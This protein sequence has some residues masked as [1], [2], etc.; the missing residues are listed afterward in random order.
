M[1]QKVL[2]LFPNLT[3]AQA[4]ELESLIECFLSDGVISEKEKLYLS[5]KSAALGIGAESLLKCVETELS[6]RLRE[7]E[8]KSSQESELDELIEIF[9]E[10]GVITDAERAILLDKAKALHLDE[11]QFREKISS[12]EA[13]R[14]VKQDS[15]QETEHHVTVQPRVE[16][17]EPSK[18]VANTGSNYSKQKRK[19][20]KV[21]LLTIL[22]PC[23]VIA[24]CAA[25]LLFLLS[26]RS[27][28]PQ[29]LDKYAESHPSL[30]FQSA[31]LRKYLVY[32]TPDGTNEHLF[33]QE[34]FQVKASG[35]Y[36]F[37]LTKLK[38]DE[39]HSSDK[40]GR[41]VL[42]YRSDTYFPLSIDV[43][44]RQEDILQ[45]EQI[46][47]Q[48]ITAEEAA[49]IAKSLAAITAVAGGALGSSIG[50]KIGRAIGPEETLIG[51]LAGGAV[52]AVAT[53]AITYV[54]SKN[55]F[56]GLKL[57]KTIGAEK[58]ESFL[59]AAKQIMQGELLTLN[60]QSKDDLE[61]LR[62]KYEEKIQLQ[63]QDIAYTL[64]WNS[65]VVNFIYE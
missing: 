57:A 29:P 6:E 14:S 31:E 19:G 28:A 45:I 3:V 64:G 50:V 55:F 8:H 60:M 58:T 20:K 2:E 61:A 15:Q 39:K 33:R 12:L 13:A 41:L 36:V 26:D 65:V 63:L 18:P 24:V 46:D 4:S 32:G 38:K 62:K 47:P 48:E 42:N 25:I 56:T 1:K 23:A 59:L 22:I 52:A 35:D 54:K 30:V 16:S 43:D 21:N 7:S 51:G 49:M 44:I 10:D 9:L 5:N 17:Q 27:P 53:G 37:D 40:E 34:V 11:K